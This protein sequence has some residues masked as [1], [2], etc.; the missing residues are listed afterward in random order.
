MAYTV[1]ISSPAL[2]NLWLYHSKN[3]QYYYNMPLWEK[4]EMKRYYETVPHDFDDEHYDKWGGVFIEQ[5]SAVCLQ[6][7][8][9][10]LLEYKEL[11]VLLLQFGSETLNEVVESN[12]W[13]LHRH[14]IEDYTKCEIR[15]PSKY[16]E[17]KIVDVLKSYPLVN[18]YQ[19]NRIVLGQLSRVF[20]ELLETGT[21][22]KS[23]LFNNRKTQ[24]VAL[25][26]PVV[27]SFNNTYVF[28]EDTEKLYRP[29]E[30]KQT[31]SRFKRCYPNNNHRSIDISSV[32]RQFPFC[33]NWRMLIIHPA[34]KNVISN[35]SK[36][37]RRNSDKTRHTWVG[38]IGIQS[39]TD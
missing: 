1:F 21:C 22:F 23:I 38:I 35:T 36:D 14:P 18:I 16:F 5:H 4:C 31:W 32:I 29:I 8:F 25:D 12:Q 11:L 19:S 3:L 13:I 27:V 34:L 17:I 6:S 2:S 30:K 26:V 20:N 37:N 9:E 33:T 7:H 24:Q 15:L 28:N 39:G 10:R